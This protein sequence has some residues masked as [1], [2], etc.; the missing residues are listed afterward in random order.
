MLK[1]RTLELDSNAVYLFS[2]VKVKLRSKKKENVKLL[3]FGQIPKLSWKINLWAVGTSVWLVFKCIQVF[4][5]CLLVIKKE[6][7]N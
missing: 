1:T 7:L 4:L 5:I 6:P 2:S 3:I